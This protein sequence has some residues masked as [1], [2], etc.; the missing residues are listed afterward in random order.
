MRGK[1]DLENASCTDKGV[2]HHTSANWGAEI[3][4]PNYSPR[5]WHGGGGNWEIRGG[6]IRGMESKV[7]N[8][9]SSEFNWLKQFDT[10]WGSREDYGLGRDFSYPFPLV[11]A[12]LECQVTVRRI[13]GYTVV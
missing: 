13:L 4:E 3:H 8:M 11:N 9:I 1:G 2:L 5:L 12:M 6:I 10:Q 7:T